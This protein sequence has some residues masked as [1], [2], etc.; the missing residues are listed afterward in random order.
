MRTSTILLLLLVGCQKPLHVYESKTPAIVIS[1][2]ANGAISL[3][4]KPVT[5]DILLI[6][7]AVQ[8]VHLPLL[9]SPSIAGDKASCVIGIPARAIPAHPEVSKVVLHY[10]NDGWLQ[11]LTQGSQIVLRF[12]KSGE[13]D[14]AFMDPALFG[15]PNQ[16]NPR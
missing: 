12:H 3:N 16:T 1:T 8:R 15:S 5:S 4:S 13:F 9:N 11:S 10:D 2:N 6:T 14:G 7:G